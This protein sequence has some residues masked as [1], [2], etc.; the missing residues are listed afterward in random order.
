MRTLFHS[1]RFQAVTAVILLVAA[2]T[3][4]IGIFTSHL[5]ASSSERQVASYS[6]VILNQ[7]CGNIDMYMTDMLSVGVK[8]SNNI[9]VQNT[10]KSVALPITD[11][12]Y[13]E[14]LNRMMSFLDGLSFVR[15]DISGVYIYNTDEIVYYKH[16]QNVFVRPKLSLGKF[17]LTEQRWYTLLEE[18]PDDSVILGPGYVRIA[19]QSPM[20]VFSLATK[21]TDPETRRDIGYL[22]VNMDIAKIDEL[23][24]NAT[25]E[26]ENATCILDG[27][28]EV[29]FSNSNIANRSIESLYDE[30]GGMNY[31]EL[32]KFSLDDKYYHVMAKKSHFSSWTIMQIYDDAYMN[33]K[34]NQY[35]LIHIV[36]IALGV[37][38]S[39]AV[40]LFLIHRVIGPLSAFRSGMSRLELGDFG[41]RLPSERKDEMGQLYDSFNQM[42]V[43]LGDLIH[44]VSDSKLKAREAQL[45]ALRSQIN[46]H[47]LYNTLASIQMMAEINDDPDVAKMISSLGRY[48]R[49]CTK[50]EEQFATVREEFGFV[51]EYITFQRIR[52]SS[53]IRFLAFV[54][55]GVLDRKI[56]RLSIQPIIE[57]S[58]I[59]GKVDKKERESGES[60]LILLSA[61]MFDEKMQIS[62]AD[63][64]VGVAPAKLKELNAQFVAMK[65]DEPVEG[66]TDSVGLANINERIKVLFGKE[67]GLQIFSIYGYGTETIL[68]FPA[69]GADAEL[70]RLAAGPAALA[71][72]AADAPDSEAVT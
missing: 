60:G 43:H 71:G 10:L 53:D 67:W 18:S 61:Q 45:K 1:L 33:Q 9:D 41:A 21:V 52:L 57:N 8:I 29:V 54:D 37:V 36:G 32:R 14:Y 24:T 72:P 35:N 30:T 51:E 62:I 69:D 23:C 15:S 6:D 20:D 59:H 58:I 55:E 65:S 49:Y 13:V 44:E 47:F 11:R 50:S 66:G 7:L 64:G 68:T 16:N 34:A 31:T 63:N 70:A 39:I 42:A 26:G 5:L 12:T 48:F 22:L 25:I 28:G 46:P 4:V 40:M 38:L 19:N 27:N 2:P 56:P 17:S 3:I